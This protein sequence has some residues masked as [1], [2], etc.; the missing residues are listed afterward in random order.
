MECL[1]SLSFI[2]L[3]IYLSKSIAAL[4]LIMPIV[5]VVIYFL[6]KIFQ[7]LGMKL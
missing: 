2:E 1:A 6:V 4:I 3:L 5:Y 7:K